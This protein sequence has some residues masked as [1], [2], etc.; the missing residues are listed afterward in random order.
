MAAAVANIAAIS[1]L[2]WGF[3]LALVPAA[4]AP[5]AGSRDLR[6]AG[7]TFVQNGAIGRNERDR[8]TAPKAEAPNSKSSPS[9][10]GMKRGPD[11]DR[12]PPPEPP[13]CQFRNQ[14]LELLV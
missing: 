6:C 2:G 7:M 13:G 4:D 8:K 14:P 10:H 12:P 1:T 3:L 5:E 11:H 9:D